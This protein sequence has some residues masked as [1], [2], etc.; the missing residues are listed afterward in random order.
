M[1]I[2]EKN[3]LILASAGSGKT[4]QLGNRVIGLVARGHEP[5]K[6]V[7]LTFTRKAAGEFADSVLMKLATAASDGTVA[8]ALRDDIDIPN[9]DFGDAL[10]RIVRALPRFTLGTMDSFFSKVVRGFQYELGLTGG[11]FELMEGARA[12]AL[13]DEMLDEILAGPLEEGAM[14]ELLHVFRRATIGR[15]E[16]G[17]ARNLLELVEEWLGKYRTAARREWAPAILAAASHE[18]WEK[19][20][21]TLAAKI[22]RGLDSITYTHG[23][24]RKAMESMVDALERHTVSGGGLNKAGTLFKNVCEAMAEGASVLEVKSNKMFVIGG[25]SGEGLREMI[26]LAAHCE[27]AAAM[28]RTRA[29]RDVV[30]AFDRLCEER[31]R[32]RGLLNFD[33]VKILMGQWASS[34]Q[35]RLRREA[36]DYRLDARYE[37]WL[38]DEFQDTSGADWAGLFPLVDEAATDDQDSLFIVGD[39]KQAIYGWRGGQ[40]GLFDEVIGR[41]GEGLAIETMAESHRSC[42]EVLALV[43]RVCG[44]AETLRMLFGEAAGRWQW[45]DHY[46]AARL[47]V[48]E[49]RGESRVETTGN[50]DARK[51]R[52]AELLEEL[53]VGTRAMT[54][55]VLVRSNDKVREVADELR[56]AGFD[57]IEEGQREPA[58]DNPVGVTMGALLNWLANPA[59]PFSWEII[60]MSPLAAVLRERFREHENAIWEGLLALAARKGFA[61]MMEEIIGPCWDA[62]SSFGHRRAGDVIAALAAFDAGGG[63]TPREA[64]DWIDRLKVS[65]SPGVAAV[66]VMTIHK[67]KGLGFDV[68]ILPDVP[69]DPVPKMQNFTVAEDTGWLCQPPAAWARQLLPPMREAEERWAADQRYEA[70]C[71]LYVALTRAKRGLYVLLEPPAKNATEDKASLANWLATSIGSTG[72]AGEVIG[73]GGVNWVETVPLLGERPTAAGDTPLGDAVPR[74]ERTT[75]SGTKPPSNVMPSPGALRFGNDFHAAF[76]HIGWIDEEAPPAPQSDAAARVASLL[77]LPAFR[78][79]F[80]RDGRHVH[81]YREQPV[82]AVIDG[83]WLSGTVDRLHVH[84]DATGLPVRVEV[85]DFKTDTVTSAGELRERYAGQMETYRLMID[86]AYPGTT[87]ECLLV[88]SS[89]GEIIAA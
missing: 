53:G 78:D 69:K 82:E 89:L 12:E 70:M 86:H 88:S 57:V 62:W 64:A 73:W 74:R 46:P 81:L 49:K 58:K 15:E 71:M 33:D 22:R 79:L 29:I 23:G 34:E 42:T 3:L 50:W 20:K 35:G 11:K 39:R 14:D 60:V 24:Q 63:T 40:V 47:A 75:P 44:D 67:S 25:I 31:L 61:G 83:K 38:L 37:H 26:L 8:D 59:D 1:K 19:E 28:V 65:Q 55:G 72:E 45:E 84:T 87:V 85:I 10:R 54:C 4:Y 68:V 51:L 13:R 9:A 18:Q 17:V 5:E 66:Q 27:M 77:K 21:S 80:R 52:T 2:L 16:A 6:I 30:S 36:V 41:F 48:P 43:N 56:A 32:R 7:A 76:E